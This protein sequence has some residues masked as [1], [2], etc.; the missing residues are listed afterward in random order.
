MQFVILLFVVCY[1]FIARSQGTSVSWKNFAE[2]D[3]EKSYQV[4]RS[5]RI[6]LRPEKRR[7]NTTS[8]SERMRAPGP[9]K[10]YRGSAKL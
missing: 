7:G 2:E 9:L 4:I 6:N 8:I 3:A 1:H 10:D 5:F